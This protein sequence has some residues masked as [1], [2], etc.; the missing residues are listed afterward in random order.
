MLYTGH[1]QHR[2]YYASFHLIDALDERIKHHD[3]L[4]S[5]LLLS[6]SLPKE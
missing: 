2:R 5:K 3:R 1:W 4:H 6:E